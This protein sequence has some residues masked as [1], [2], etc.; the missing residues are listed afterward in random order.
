MYAD[1]TVLYAHGKTAEEVAQK[2]TKD[3]KKVSLWLKNSCLTLNLDK[4]SF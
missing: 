3:I 1:D 2:L 4:K